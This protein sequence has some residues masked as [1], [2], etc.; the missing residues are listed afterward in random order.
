MA[1]GGTI[2]L[3][4]IVWGLGPDTTK[5]RAA[6]SAILDFGEA[7]ERAAD[8]AEDGAKKTEAAFRKQEAAIVSAQMKMMQFNAAARNAGAP[9][10]VTN[11]STLA[12]KELSNQMVMGELTQLQ[13][14]R[15]QQRFSTEMLRSKMALTDF[16]SGIGPAAAE[17][18][19]FAGVLSQLAKAAQLTTGPLSGVAYRMS[20][21]SQLM[22]DNTLHLALMVGGIAA[23]AFAF[24]KLS[25]SAVH[26]EEGLLRTRM[27][28][29][30][31]SNSTA[32]AQSD[33]KYTMDVAQQFGESFENI[34]SHFAK[35][36]L[37]AR[38]SSIEGAKVRDMFKDIISY[39][40]NM[41]QTQDELGGQL[42]HVTEMLTRQRLQWRDLRGFLS[43]EYPG[44]LRIAAQ[45]MNMT[46]G[47]FDRALKR[48]DIIAADFLPRFF[49]SINQARGFDP[50]K[51]VDNLFSSQQNLG[52]AAL[53]MNNALNQTLGLS[54]S[55]KSALDRIAG[56]FDFLADHMDTSIKVIGT[57]AGA[58]AGLFLRGSVVSGIT[59]VIGAV[60]SL[61]GSMRTLG[62]VTAIVEA[63]MNPAMWINIAAAVAGGAI[64]WALFDNIVST[65]KDNLIGALPSL[66]AF[67]D[68]YEKTSTAASSATKELLANANAT[69]QKAQADLVAAQAA[70]LF[71]GA[72]DPE[73]K[74]TGKKV[75]K[76]L[77]E[78][79]TDALKAFGTAPGDSAATESG[80]K[81]FIDAT[82]KAATERITAAKD[83]ILKL[84]AEIARGQKNLNDQLSKE[85]K[86]K[87]TGLEETDQQKRMRLAMKEMSQFINESNAQYNAMQEG[88]KA[89]QDA[90][91]KIQ[92]E[93]TIEGWRD[94][95]ERA[96]FTATEVD[97][98]MKVLT[99][100]IVRLR[101]AQLFDKQFVFIGKVVADSIGKLGT[102]SVNKFVDALNNGSLKSLK[103]RDFVV[104]A[105]GDVEKKIMELAI[106][107][108]ILNSLF[109]G[110]NQTL[111][112]TSGG[113]GLG[114][115][116]GRIFGG[117]SIFGGASSAGSG[118][119]GAANFMHGGSNATKSK[120]FIDPSIFSGAPRLHTGLASDEFPAIL[121][122]GET[123][124]PKGGS[125]GGG[126]TVMINAHY[127]DHQGSAGNNPAAQKQGLQAMRR[128]L[129]S[130][131]DGRLIEARRTGGIYNRLGSTV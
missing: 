62:V 107:N 34:A 105:L 122:D 61:I 16:K 128:E 30:A 17:A 99:A 74:D 48:G 75:A 25:E 72:L 53:R 8:S 37:A 50:S 4:D 49:K 131:I 44:A 66:K 96:G 80:V 104:G 23:A 124:I 102:D 86:A 118:I 92:L 87:N 39:S 117:G 112:F 111:S 18:A 45:A 7:T 120:L 35:I 69:L 14:N 56:A 12:F 32:I 33:M 116:F 109:G 3:G 73:M 85:S 110:T 13:F 60:T 21:L 26:A 113:T 11:Q 106:L 52:N 41:A 24:T 97:A 47:D 94:K 19:G 58:F 27:Q 59:A 98:K 71:N 6:L 126:S 77:W 1:S 91:E 129:E 40:S 36:E 31:L 115:L 114:G 82:A 103:F 42:N 65:N 88:P 121:Q 95:L 43:T 64:A 22:S 68:A 55:Y 15:A 125:A 54:D 51:T 70:N 93:K 89:L 10:A 78:S 57:V 29:F 90:M 2:N 9:V 5:L 63:L 38:G 20:T 67:N 123:V 46:V 83:A 108:P 28:L 84:Q 76:T 101:D 127:H 81:T 130:L 119:G 100:T 79:F